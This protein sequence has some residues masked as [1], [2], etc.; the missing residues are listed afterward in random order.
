[1]IPKKLL[2]S[3]NMMVFDKFLNINTYRKKIFKLILN[4]LNNEILTDDL[5]INPNKVEEDK[6]GKVEGEE[7]KKNISFYQLT[8]ETFAEFYSYLL[9]LEI[10]LC[11]LTS[12]QFL[13]VNNESSFND[14]YH[15]IIGGSSIFDMIINLIKSDTFGIQYKSNIDGLKN[16]NTQ[17]KTE[18]ASIENIEENNLYLY[19]INLLNYFINICCGFKKERIDIIVDDLDKNDKLKSV[20]D[21]FFDS[22][23]NL[24]NIINKLE[25]L[26]FEN[27]RYN[28]GNAIFDCENS[29]FKN[30]TR[31]NGD[32][33]NEL[34]NKAEFNTKYASLIDTFN[35]V[36]SVMDS[37]LEKYDTSKIEEDE[38]TYEDDRVILPVKEWN[39]ITDVLYNDL[40]NI[41][42][43]TEELEKSRNA[44]EEEKNKNM[45]LQVKYEN[46]EKMK[47]ENDG[48]LGELMVKL[49]KFSQLEAANE[50]NTKKIQ[51]YQIAVECLQ[52]TVNDYE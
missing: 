14:V 8:I 20:A 10:F 52:N 2:E 39:N 47:K 44:V 45:D 27:M 22:N 36:C 32:I 37:A 12:D 9:K 43:V 21:S 15:S 48:K 30:L 40:E 50:E 17:I 5:G 35:R 38:N 25:P 3:G 7:K 16:I 31:K 1:M 29:Y 46:L 23:K 26:F 33:E 13:K 4:Q 34:N 42:K 49:G 41:S 24:N 18:M 19:L 51:K 11:E 6:I 28:L